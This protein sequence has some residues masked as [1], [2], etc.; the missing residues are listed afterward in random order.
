[1]FM[2]KI[3]HTKWGYATINNDGYYTISSRKEGYNRKILHRL[4]WE[5]F[6]GCEI[7]K[8][9]IIHHKDG[10]KTNNCILNLQLMKHGTH[11]HLHMNG[12]NNHM[13][14]KHRSETVKKRISHANSEKN[15]TTGLYRVYKHKIKNHEQGFNWRYNYCDEN[16]KR[17]SLNSL[18]LDKLKEKV[19][20][21]GLEWKIVN[22]E[23]YREV[24][25]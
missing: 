12:E 23:K 11:N 8:G 1:M 6:Y 7:P 24:C 21:K 15:S 20:D 5:D 10:N 4:I 3:L 9:Y 18:D 13:Y 17:R 19:L 14:G 25:L 16:G 22:E 2:N